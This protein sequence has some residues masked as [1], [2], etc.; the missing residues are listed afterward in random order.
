MAPKLSHFF[1]FLWDIDDPAVFGVRGQ[2][3]PR[4]SAVY[5]VFK[6]A[7]QWIHALFAQFVAT[8]CFSATRRYA[9]QNQAT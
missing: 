6:L 4:A 7:E 9:E 8:R 1:A 3:I 2:H 5:D